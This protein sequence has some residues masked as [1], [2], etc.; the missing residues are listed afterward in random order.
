MTT[1]PWQGNQSPSQFIFHLL[2]KY[3]VGK[4]VLDIGCA[5]AWYASYLHKKGFDVTCVDLEDIREDKSLKFIQASLID[6]P[7]PNKSFD[8]VLCINVLEHIKDEPKALSE[9]SRVC[10]QRLIVSVPNAD[11][12]L[13]QE[14]NLTFKHQ[15]DKSHYRSYQVS[16]IKEKLGKAGFGTLE[17]FV[18][19]PVIP[20][21]FAEFI[22]NNLLRTLIKKII[23]KFFILK[24][25]KNEKL[26]EDIFVIATI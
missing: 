22:P 1:T 12:S 13:L 21:V 20:S 6:L 7:F 5:K 25:L 2:D 11:D 17:T 8:T 4:T 23:N 9:L 26:M 3:P 19:G 15:V 24:I 14:Y 10:K 16:E 18:H